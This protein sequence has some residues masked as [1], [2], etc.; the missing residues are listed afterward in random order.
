MSYRF[1]RNRLWT[2]IVIVVGVSIAAALF[3]APLWWTVVWS[4]W[5]TDAIFSFPPKVIPGPDF[6]SNF[7]HLQGSV[8]IIR[9]LVNSIIVTVASIVGALT[10]CT[11]AGY[12]FAKMR[13]AGRSVLFGLVLSTMVVPG[14]ITVVPLFVTL[15]KLGWI[16]TYQGLI[17]PG[18]VPAI[19][20]FFMRSS[21]QQTI[22]DELIEVARIDGASEL[23]I[24]ARIILPLLRPSLA[25]LSILLCASTWG[26]LFW[27][28]VVL[29]SPDM[30]TLPV[31][32]STLFGTTTHP[33]DQMMVGSLLTVVPPLIFFFLMQRHFIRSITRTGLR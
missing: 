18:L 19:G 7:H 6:T 25:A 26:A 21:V 33:Y 20:V 11:L 16:D 30:Y 22:P 5:H 2:G 9:A 14:Q 31:A 13:F 32:L 23:R 12:V 17:L 4:N 1:G 10:F 8:N 27:P 28:L 15:V 3:L 24:F 29:R